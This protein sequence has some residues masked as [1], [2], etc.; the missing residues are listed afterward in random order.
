MELLKNIFIDSLNGFALS[1]VPLFLFQIICATVLAYIL[2]ILLNKKFNESISKHGPLIA[3]LVCILSAIVKYSLPFTAL[4]AAALILLIPKDDNRK[5]QL[6]QFAM[7]IIGV[8]CGVGSVIQ[9]VIGV[10]LFALLLI[11]TPLQKD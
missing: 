6:S 10:I 11:I 7:V 3:A 2:Q 4:G 9:S 8:G 1:D 5:S